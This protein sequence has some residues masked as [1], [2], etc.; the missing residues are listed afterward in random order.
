M[1][2]LKEKLKIGKWVQVANG[3]WYQIKSIH[4]PSVDIGNKHGVMGSIF[5]WIITDI[6][7]ER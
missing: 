7:D 1:G 5:P 4:Y 2:H 6:K 3:N